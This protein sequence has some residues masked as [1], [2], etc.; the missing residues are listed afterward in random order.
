ML[1]TRA[2]SEEAASPP[3]HCQDAGCTDDQAA[4]ERPDQTSQRSNGSQ[5]DRLTTSV[6][7]RSLLTLLACE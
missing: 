3:E 7:I 5:A 1:F 2:S 6:R 4:A